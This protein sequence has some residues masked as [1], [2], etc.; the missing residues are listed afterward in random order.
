[1]ISALLAQIGL[2]LLARAVGGA[3]S[4]I[5]HPVAAAAAKA[6][7]A[8]DADIAG[9][10]ISPAQVD[11]ANRHVE[12]MEELALARDVGVLTQINRTIRTEATAE[13]AYV[14]RMRPTLVISWRS[15]GRRRCW[16]SLL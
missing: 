11:A 5:D 6:L 1:M 7:N 2:P 10:N 15:A 12:R 14:R 16:P 4:N 13:D 8:V 3:L 9:G